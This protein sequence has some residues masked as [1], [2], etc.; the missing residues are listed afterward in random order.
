MASKFTLPFSK[1]S[2][3]DV[4]IAGGKGASLREMFQA[5]FPVPVGFV[6]LA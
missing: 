3:D 2:K 1:I 5:G 6:V 4:K